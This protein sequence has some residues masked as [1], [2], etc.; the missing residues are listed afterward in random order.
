MARRKT[1]TRYR[2]DQID[3]ALNDLLAE[4]GETRFSRMK[5]TTLE[6]LFRERYKAGPLG[7]TLLGSN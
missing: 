2:Y 4:I 3:T 7:R 1:K 5:L 6:K